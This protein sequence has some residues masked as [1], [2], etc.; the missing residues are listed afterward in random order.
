M[1][2]CREFLSCLDFELCAQHRLV[3]MKLKTDT[4]ESHGFKK[5]TQIPTSKDNKKEC[6]GNLEKERRQRRQ[7]QV[8]GQP[9]NPSVLGLQ[10]QTNSSYM[11]IISQ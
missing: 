2:F 11:S 1:L 3:S 8:W 10:K 5:Y 6:T 9:C 4:K 7:T